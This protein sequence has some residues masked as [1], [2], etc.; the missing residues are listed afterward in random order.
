MRFN[1]NK[2]LSGTPSDQ[3]K[4]RTDTLTELGVSV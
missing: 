2:K 4:R 1:Y 3:F